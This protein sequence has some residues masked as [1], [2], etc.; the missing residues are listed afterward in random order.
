MMARL[1]VELGARALRGVRLEGWFRARARVV[2]VECDPANPAEAVEALRQ[3]LGPARRIAL[4]LDVPLLFM[5]RVKLPPLGAS[6]KRNILRLEPERFFPVRAEEIVPAVRGDDDL[7]FAAKE[8]PLAAW[9]AALEELGPVDVVEPGPLALARALAHAQLT[10]AVVLLDGQADGIGV[11][12]IRE[13]RVTRARRVFG[14]LDDAAAAL[15]EHGG[16]SGPIYLTP[17]NEDRVRVL[18]TLLPEAVVQPLPTVADIVGPFLP[19]YGAALAIGGRPNFARTLVSPELGGRITVRWRRELGLAIA[20]AAAAVVFA[21]ASADAWRARATRGLEASLQVLQ[22]R[23]TP[24]MRR[25]WWRSSARLRNSRRCAFAPRQPARRWATGPMKT[26]PWL[27]DTLRRLNPR[28]R[29]VVL[30]GAL[31]SAT[32]LVASALQGLLQRYADE[33]SVQLNR[34][35]VASQPRPDRPGLLA[36]PVQ[37][38]C[39][40]DIYGL[41]DFL[42]RLEQGEKVLVVDELSLNAAVGVA[43]DPSVGP[44]AGQNPGPRVGPRVAKPSQYLSWSLRLHG[45]YGAVGGAIGS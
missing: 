17:W 6:E 35:D 28:E 37:L 3:H 38:Q 31:V 24:R 13:G 14:T 20:A 7:V 25:A 10:D 32:A 40:G 21:F 23:A 11:V 42:S 2:E 34:V 45:L 30:G 43:F 8:A 16:A 22:Q 33:S 1:G 15:L 5:K 18:G 44:Q 26:L 12:E 36:I 39:Q 27:F 29:R 4:A 19:A 9:V 41:V